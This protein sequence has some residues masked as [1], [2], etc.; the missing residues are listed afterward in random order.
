MGSKNL[1][2]LAVNGA[3]KIPVADSADINRIRQEL[4][5]MQGEGYYN[6]FGTPLMLPGMETTTVK[7]VHCHSCTQ[8]C[9]RT[10]QRTPSGMEGIRKCQT[11]V[12]YSRYNARFHG[13]PN[14]EVFRA[15]DLANDYSFCVVEFG[16]LLMWLD[17]CFQQGI[18]TEEETGLELSKMGSIEFLEDLMRKVSFRE[19]FGS[20]LSEGVYRASMEHGEMSQ[21]MAEGFLTPR[22][23]A[24]PYGPKVFTPSALIYATEPRPLITELHELC[25]PLTKWAIW[26][27]AKGELPKDGTVWGQDAIHKDDRLY[28]TTEVLRNI[29][30]KFW[31]GEKAVDFST[32]EGKALAGA[33]VQDRQFTKESLILCDFAWPVYDSAV[34]EDHV[35]DPNLE[36][37]LLSAVTGMEIDQSGL[38]HIAQ[39]LFALNRAILLREGRKGREDDVLPEFLFIEREEPPMDVFALHNPELYLPGAG[40]AIV[41][42][43]GKALSKHDF[44]LMLD[45]YYAIRGW[46]VKTG[47]PTED[48]LRALDLDEVVPDLKR[49]EKLG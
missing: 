14:E 17:F 20:V 24:V 12:F 43:K 23:R 21:K 44:E 47:Y 4:R 28:V 10:V 34:S 22:G 26:Y 46:D 38:D 11:P 7:K 35:G 41:S 27:T 42:R 9:W 49:A 25:E 37:R 48:T 36:S 33:K 5:D 3:G 15:T 19:G 1:K 18:L 13:G 40:D 30:E 29:A 6:L 2:A 32:W 16:F 45:D 31:G 8:G 39:R